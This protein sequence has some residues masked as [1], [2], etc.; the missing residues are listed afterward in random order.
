[1]AWRYMAE[2]LLSVGLPAVEVDGEFISA[3]ESIV[4]ERKQLAFGFGGE[5]F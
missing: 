3:L 5:F 2:Q 1:M 4:R